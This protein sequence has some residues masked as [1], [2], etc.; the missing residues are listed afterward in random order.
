VAEQHSNAVAAQIGELEDR[1]QR[2]ALPP[3]R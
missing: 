2:S 3:P 1:M